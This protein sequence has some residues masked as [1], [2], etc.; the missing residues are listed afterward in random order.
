[1]EWKRSWRSGTA[2]PSHLLVVLASQ[3][4]GLDP[5]PEVQFYLEFESSRPSIRQR[6]CVWLINSLTSSL[7]SGR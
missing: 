1:V 6:A 7:T 2:Q 3:S 4:Y 5:V